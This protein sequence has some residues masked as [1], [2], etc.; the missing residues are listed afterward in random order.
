MPP[1][2]SG[3]PPL[4]HIFGPLSSQVTPIPWTHAHTWQWM[5]PQTSLP[6]PTSREITNR[7][8]RDMPL[9]GNYV[10]RE[11]FPHNRNNVYA[12]RNNFHR[13]NRKP[14]RFEQ[15]QVQYDQ[16]AYYGTPM[17]NNLGLEWQGYKNTTSGKDAVIK[18]MT[19]PLPA[20]PI[21]PIPPGIMSNRRNKERENQDVEIVLINNC[22][23]HF[24]NLMLQQELI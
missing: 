14:A 5:T 3:V 21:S 7:F 2:P 8:Q 20:H 22:Y 18:H 15:T 23:K 19:V 1:P 13:K 11:R 17:T 9:K 12:Q 4:P 6:P 10:R 16:T 24:I